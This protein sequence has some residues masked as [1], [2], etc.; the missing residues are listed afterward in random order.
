MCLVFFE[1]WNVQS[2]YMLDLAMHYLYMWDTSLS[3]WVCTC[4]ARISIYLYSGEVVLQY[5]LE[6]VHWKGWFVSFVKY[7]FIVHLFF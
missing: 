4:S 1:F 6:C 5:T 3:G 2:A 7:N